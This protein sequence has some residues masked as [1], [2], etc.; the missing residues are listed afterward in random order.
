MSAKGWM[1][2]EKS[3]RGI[4]PTL[5]TSVASTP[6]S[7]LKPSRHPRI[8]GHKRVTNTQK[9]Q[10]KK[11]DSKDEERKSSS[12]LYVVPTQYDYDIEKLA[13]G[14][15]YTAALRQFAAMPAIFAAVPSSLRGPLR[16]FLPCPNLGPNIFYWQKSS[17]RRYR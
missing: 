8:A 3:L 13:Q 2:T 15:K 6:Q 7:L 9:K 1:S 4:R 11:D 5:L 16:H 12:S 14:L 10:R 17:S